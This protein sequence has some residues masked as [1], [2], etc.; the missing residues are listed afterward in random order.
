MQPIF[1]CGFDVAL[2]V[3]LRIWETRDVTSSW[4]GIVTSRQWWHN[5]LFRTTASNVNW[6]TDVA[7]HVYRLWQAGDTENS[8][9]RTA[10]V[11]RPKAAPF[12]F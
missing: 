1:T 2:P 11:S 4:Y 12:V 8:E 6:W 9:R 10:A 7:N 3:R 5:E